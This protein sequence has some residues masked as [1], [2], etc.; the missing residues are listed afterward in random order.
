MGVAFLKDSF[1][2][3]NFIHELKSHKPSNTIFSLRTIIRSDFCRSK[4]FL[5]LIVLLL[6]VSR[7]KTEKTER[8]Y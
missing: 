7:I 8:I 5:F 1:T 6:D 4:I 3:G 2:Q